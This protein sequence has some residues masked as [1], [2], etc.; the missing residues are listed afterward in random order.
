YS[1]I[2][3]IIVVSDVQ[4]AFRG[5]VARASSARPARV[6]CAGFHPASISLMGSA[7]S[8]PPRRCH[9]SARPAAL[10]VS[11]IS[12]GGTGSNPG[13][14]PPPQRRAPPIAPGFGGAGSATTYVSSFARDDANTR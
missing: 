14:P 2:L 6:S 11:A 5:E 4:F 10:A 9:S 13:L 8:I 1:A 3:D 7:T 12:A